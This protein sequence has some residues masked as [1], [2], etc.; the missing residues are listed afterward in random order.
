MHRRAL[1]ARAFRTGG[2]TT[3]GGDSRSPESLTR[4]RIPRVDE[5][6][7]PTSLPRRR[8]SRADES[9][10]PTSLPRRRVS[11]ADESHAVGELR[12]RGLVRSSGLGSQQGRRQLA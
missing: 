5:S 10:A 2:L 8:V 6:P 1:R 9:P 3:N 7:A 4:R 12:T 11:R